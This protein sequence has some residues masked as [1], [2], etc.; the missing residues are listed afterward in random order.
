MK[1][2]CAD[3]QDRLAEN[4]MDEEV[5]QHVNSCP[6]CSEIV[7]ALGMID[8]LIENSRRHLPPA[9]ILKK[10]IES[11]DSL[12][13]MEWEESLPSHSPSARSSN[14]RAARY[15]AGGLSLA[16]VFVLMF[17]TG[18]LFQDDLFLSGL[19]IFG[20]RKAEIIEGVGVLGGVAAFLLPGPKKFLISGVFFG[21]VATQIVLTILLGRP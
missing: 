6:D 9:A 16:A 12:R 4:L 20:G 3:I 5:C 19:S 8:H 7:R 17:G 10:V 1:D 11:G 18:T 14:Y 15:F 2:I 21:L 13:L